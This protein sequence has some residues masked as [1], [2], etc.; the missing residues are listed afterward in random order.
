MPFP[1]S[2]VYLQGEGMERAW[3]K[4]ARANILR[5]TSLDLFP[6]SVHKC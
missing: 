3:Y 1:C 6:K 5:M 4:G 2:M